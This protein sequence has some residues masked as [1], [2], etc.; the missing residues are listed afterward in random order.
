[1]I[2]DDMF[3]SSVRSAGD[4]A[5]VFEFNGKT[6]YFYLYE[7]EGKERQKVLRAIKVLSRAPDFSQEEVE[8]RWDSDE[9]VVGLFFQNHLVAVFDAATGKTYGGELVSGRELNIPTL[10]HSI[11][12]N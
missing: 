10:I 5:G 9:Q 2:D 8:I 1:M 3:Q 4:L 11:F 6:G 7:L 12:D